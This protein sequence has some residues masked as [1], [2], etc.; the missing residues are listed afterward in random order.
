MPLTL[1][2]ELS[3]LYQPYALPGQ[4]TMSVF[5]YAEA[6][7][8]T[9]GTGLTTIPAWRLGEALLWPQKER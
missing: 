1:P 6:P 4:R 3:A 8:A 5:L 2:G 9:L 7:P